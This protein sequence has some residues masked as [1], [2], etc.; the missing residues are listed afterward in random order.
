MSA[1]YTAIEDALYSWVATS[2]DLPVIWG[3]QNARQPEGDYIALFPDG[4]FSIGQD[5]LRYL[6]RDPSPAPPAEAPEAGE[7]IEAQVVGEREGHLLLQAYSEA[8]H[9]ALM[10]FKML[11]KA[12]TAL[13]LPSVHTALSSAGISVF[14]TGRV[15]NIPALL[16][17][18]IQGR[19]SLRVRFYFRDSASE[20]LTFIEK[21]HGSL[22]LFEGAP[23]IPFTVESP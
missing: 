7:E 18:D 17:A 9:G 1:D 13:A 23:P 6:T 22:G 11:G 8:A 2:T 4:P 10:A 12:Q 16:E 20:F 19:A 21:V 5:S 14:D 15:Q 3:N